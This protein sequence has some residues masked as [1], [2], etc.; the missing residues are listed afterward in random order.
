M[1]MFFGKSVYKAMKNFSVQ[2]RQFSE[3]RFSGQRSPQYRKAI[4]TCIY[5]VFYIQLS[6]LSSPLCV[7]TGLSDR[8]C[9]HPEQ[10]SLLSGIFLFPISFFYIIRKIFPEN[11]DIFRI[12]L[13]IIRSRNSAHSIQSV[14]TYTSHRHNLSF[15]E[16]LKI[17][18]E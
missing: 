18:S 14:M 10:I 8:I 12:L 5:I 13:R 16:A 1:F 2:L 17:M 4:M 3:E 11:T 6:L 9:F 15:F 7:C